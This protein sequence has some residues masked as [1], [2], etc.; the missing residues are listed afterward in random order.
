[1]LNIKVE[2]LE[3]LNGE[4][5]SKQKLKDLMKKLQKGEEIVVNEG[6][7]FDKEEVFDFLLAARDF[8]LEA[9]IK[10]NNIKFL[11]IANSVIREV[12]NREKRVLVID[13][14]NFFH[15]T[16]HAVPDLV[17]ENGEHVVVLKS[18]INIIKYIINT[19][20]RYTHIIFSSEGGNLKRKQE[21]EGEDK[22]YK[23]N[24]KEVDY[25]LLESI[26]LTEA[27]L[28]ELGFTVLRRYQYEAD[29]ILASIAHNSYKNGYSVTAFTTDKDAYQ[30]FKYPG[31]EIL[32]PKT[33]E[34]F[35]RQKCVEKFGVET[36]DF[37]DYQ[38]IVGDTADNIPGVKGFGAVVA[39]ELIT[40]YHNLEAIYE[41][42]ESLWIEDIDENL[43]P[44]KRRA[45]I[46][47]AQKKQQKLIESKDLAFKSRNLCRLETNLFEKYPIDI[48]YFS[49]TPYKNM[50]KIFA[51]R[52]KKYG[53]VY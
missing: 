7:D 29:D 24:R 12:E 8:V 2:R 36:E 27:V 41:N 26:K 6:V 42:L 45:K 10:T 1:M 4:Y 46:A 48:T 52:L 13:N 40:K 20:D 39:K 25:V 17:N 47:T 35:G 30:L 19:Q 9:K 31:F 33:K 32:D 50:E 3:N 16:F 21:T 23:A 22:K 34:I 11:K 15:R 38:A 43:T 18:V 49:P 28:E 51:S 14:H 53:I 44:A 37:I 5:L